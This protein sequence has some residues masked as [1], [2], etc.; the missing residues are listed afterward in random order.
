MKD[1]G[2]ESIIYYAYHPAAIA[3]CRQRGYREAYGIEEVGPKGEVETSYVFYLPLK[4]K[5]KR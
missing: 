2:Y 3:I 5:L 4:K 1:K